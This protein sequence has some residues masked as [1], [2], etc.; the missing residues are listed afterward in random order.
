MKGGN[1]NGWSYL[2]YWWALDVDRC[3]FG[4]VYTA[5]NRFP[6]IYLLIVFY[7]SAPC[8]FAIKGS[9]LYKVLLIQQGRFCMPG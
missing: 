3:N 5:S 2:W 4:I 9:L 6:C 8:A 7:E 1:S